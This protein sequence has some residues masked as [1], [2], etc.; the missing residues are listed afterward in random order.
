MLRE[1]KKNIYTGAAMVLVC[2]ICWLLGQIVEEYFIGSSYKGY[3]KANMMVEEGKI[4]P[5]LKAPIPRRN[6]CDLM[7]PCPPAYYPFRISSG[8]AMMIFP[9]LCFNDQRIFQSNSGKLGRGM[10]IAVFKVDTGALV[11]IKSF[12]MYE[13]DFSKPMETFLKSIPTG[14]FIFIATHDDGGTR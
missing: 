10:N 14:S 4:E 5:K 7:Q 3:A 9:K 2:C 13:G 6:P 12:D 8:V 11:E 1:I